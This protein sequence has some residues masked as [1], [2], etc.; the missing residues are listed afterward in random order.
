L[1]SSPRREVPFAV[2]T[3]Y[4]KAYDET[5]RKMT[6]TIEAEDRQAANAELRESGL[7]VYRLHDYHKLRKALQKRKKRQRLITITGTAAVVLSLVFSSL[8]VRYA[9]RERA[10]D[11]DEYRRTGIVAGNPGLIMAKTME[12]R[13]FGS[14]IHGVWQSFCPGAVTGL[15]VTKLFMSVYVSR[16]IRDLSDNDLEVLASNTVRAL[17]RRFEASVCTLLVVEGDTTILEVRYNAITSSTRVKF[18]R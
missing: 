13:E 14:Y 9:G 16:S 17:Q 5:G 2:R 12:E 11:I 15:E 18:Y 4:F 7:R 3:F 8:M 6:G 10:P 1:R